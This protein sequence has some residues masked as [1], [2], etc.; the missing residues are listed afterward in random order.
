[1]SQ[2]TLLCKHCKHLQPGVL[3][4]ELGSSHVPIMLKKTVS[5]GFSRSLLSLG[6]CHSLYDLLNL[7]PKKGP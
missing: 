4:F 7:L 1:M 6:K 2:R 3:S 5:A